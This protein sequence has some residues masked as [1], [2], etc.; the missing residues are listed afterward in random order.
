MKK[1][2]HKTNLSSVSLE[3]EL[4]AFSEQGYEIFKIWYVKYDTYE[5]VAFKD[6]TI[7]SNAP[8]GY[9]ELGNPIKYGVE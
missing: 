8:N 9:D 2:S 6:V 1:W 7:N 4:N 3:P 5:I